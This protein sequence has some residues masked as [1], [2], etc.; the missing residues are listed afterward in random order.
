MFCGRRVA[1]QMTARLKRGLHTSK[2][3]NIPF[4]T[5]IKRFHDPH[6]AMLT[7][8]IRKEKGAKVELS[9]RRKRPEVT[10]WVSLKLAGGT[11]T[12]YCISCQ[13]R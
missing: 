10:E 2:V 1:A 4:F 8:N 3:W 11:K 9:G 13:G 6:R 5:E 12:I 7:G